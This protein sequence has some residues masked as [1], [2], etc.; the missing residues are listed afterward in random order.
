MFMTLLTTWTKFH[1]QIQQ[2]QHSVTKRE[3]VKTANGVAMFPDAKQPAA[4]EA[5]QLTI[6]PIVKMPRHGLSVPQAPETP[7]PRAGCTGIAG[8]V[9]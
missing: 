9:V 5:V 2:C 3:P 7:H 4:R 6:G 1:S 8:S